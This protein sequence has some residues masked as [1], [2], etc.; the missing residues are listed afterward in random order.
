MQYVR[1]GHLSNSVSKQIR[2]NYEVYMLLMCI[3]T[4]LT[5]GFYIYI[6]KQVSRR[7]TDHIPDF[8]QK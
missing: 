6:P 5:M 2:N 1:I 4:H 3:Y 8:L 7:L